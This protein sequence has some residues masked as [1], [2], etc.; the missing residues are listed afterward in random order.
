MQ[1]LSPDVAL[2]TDM[3]IMKYV[4]AKIYCS[5]SYQL[6]RRTFI[7]LFMQPA[8]LSNFAHGLEKLR[9][10]DFPWKSRLPEKFVVEF[11]AKLLAPRSNF[12][13]AERTPF[14]E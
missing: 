1:F 9:N 2:T 6:S 14:A 11:Y 10:E 13:R 7:A 3:A 4:V 12:S 5:R 8:N